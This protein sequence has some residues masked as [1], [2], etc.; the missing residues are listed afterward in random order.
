MLVSL[1]Q[2]IH[3]S[4]GGEG[5]LNEAKILYKNELITRDWSIAPEPEWSLVLHGDLHLR[6]VLSP[7][8]RRR[9]FVITVQLSHVHT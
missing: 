4:K 6:T 2:E 8:I 3:S 9:H 1:N 7:S 5:R